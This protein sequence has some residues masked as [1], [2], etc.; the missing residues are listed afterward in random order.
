VAVERDFSLLKI[1]H[2]GSGAYPAYAS[3]GT[4]GFS[5]WVK[6][7]G[8]DVYRSPTS[9]TKVKNER[10]YTASPPVCHRGV[11]WGFTYLTLAIY[12]HIKR[13]QVCNVLM[14]LHTKPMHIHTTYAH[15]SYAGVHVIF[16]NTNFECQLEVLWITVT[17]EKYKF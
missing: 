2:T 3:M 13:R 4:G 15:T 9:S 5:P 7:P 6:R 8:R 1:M 17:Y 14:Y 16:H 12:M 11:H 10:S